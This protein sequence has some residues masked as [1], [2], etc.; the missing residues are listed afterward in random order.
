M[1]QAKILEFAF[2]MPDPTAAR[3]QKWLAGGGRKIIQAAIEESHSD[4][5]ILDLEVLD[6]EEVDAVAGILR[7]GGTHTDT[8]DVPVRSV[9]ALTG[10][11]AKA[12]SV[13]SWRELF[14]HIHA[15]GWTARSLKYFD[16]RIDGAKLDAPGAAGELTLTASG[17]L[18]S[19]QNGQHRMVAGACWLGARDRVEARLREVR[20]TV[21]P[22]HRGAKA[23]VVA[24]ARDGY[25]IQLAKAST[26]CSEK[27]NFRIRAQK[28]GE[29][30]DF[31]V[32]GLDV[33][34]L[35]ST[36]SGGFREFFR[37]DKDNDSWGWV[38]VS[39]RLIDAL[40]D[41]DWLPETLR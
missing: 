18:V 17:G 4:H 10:T 6:S 23:K 27:P 37:T 29:V 41:D 20:V 2:T 39:K 33:G 40:S 22:V 7:V 32:K 19:V 34:E 38:P 14:A 30:R 26:H 16:E 31:E 36:P 1:N 5:P 35:T 15:V 12:I 21:S 25:A 13:G 28:S 24:L 3:V 9:V 8:I 11:R